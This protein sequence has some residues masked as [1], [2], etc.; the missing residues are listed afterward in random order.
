MFYGK[1]EMNEEQVLAIYKCLY[2]YTIVD[3]ETKRKHVEK[4]EERY[5]GY[6]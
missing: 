5:G 1:D 3:E 2:P 4:I 6:I